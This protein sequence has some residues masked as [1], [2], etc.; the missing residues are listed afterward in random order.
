MSQ[1]PVTDCIFCKIVS[2]EI[3]GQIVHQ[4]EWVTA[5]RDVRPQA[6]THILIVSN[7]HIGGLSDVTEADAEVMGRILLT[8]NALAREQGFAGNGFRIVGNQGRDG[9]QTVGHL[10]F[11]LLAGRTMTWPPG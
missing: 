2:R 4:D 9:G 5:F 11:H 7:R 3:A 6:P 10:H 1:A 8:A